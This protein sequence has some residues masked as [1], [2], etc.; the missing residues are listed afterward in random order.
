MGDDWVPLYISLLIIFIIGGIIPLCIS[1][2]VDTTQAY[3]SFVDSITSFIS[4]GFSFSVFGIFDLE[5]NPFL[6]FGEGFNSF[7]VSQLN[8]FSYIPPL[9]SVP[10]LIIG[11]IGLV[12]G[13]IN[14]VKSLP[15]L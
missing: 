9:I 14:L 15:F 1:G 2:F 3:N 8:A 7:M 4:D 11:T 12:W 5:L 10:L 13:I 6:W